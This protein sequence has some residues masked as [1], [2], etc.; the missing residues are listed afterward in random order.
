MEE[1]LVPAEDTGPL[2]SSPALPELEE[3]DQEAV[4][5]G[6]RVGLW[7]KETRPSSPGA[8]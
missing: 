8:Y 2:R 5:E 1:R 6:H 7:E 4:H 3:S